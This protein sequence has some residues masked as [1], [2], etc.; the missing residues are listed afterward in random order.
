MKLLSVL[1]IIFFT[2]AFA[3]GCKDEPCGADEVSFTSQD[4]CFCVE[5]KYFYDISVSIFLKSQW[6]KSGT[7]YGQYEIRLFNKRDTGASSVS[8][9]LGPSII[10]TGFQISGEYNSITIPRIE[11]KNSYFFSV[12]SIGRDFPKIGIRSV[13][14]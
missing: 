2:L 7:H 11:K 6:D 4:I 8:V 14:Y 13:T 5:E 9:S 12:T 10:T 1:F 3:Y